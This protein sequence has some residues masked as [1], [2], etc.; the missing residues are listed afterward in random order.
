MGL[1]QTLE[2]KAAVERV[3][4]LPF[5]LLD[6]DAGYH[7]IGQQTF[8]QQ[9]VGVAVEVQ[10]AGLRERVSEDETGLYVLPGDPPSAEAVGVAVLAGGAVLAGPSGIG[11]VAVGGGA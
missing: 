7:L 11:V 2:L 5:R 9:P 3:R 1:S 8:S 4:L 10:R 6:E